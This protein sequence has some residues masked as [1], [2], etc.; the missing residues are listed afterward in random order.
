MWDYLYSDDAAMAFLL[1][2][3]HG[4]NGAVYPLGSGECRPLCEYVKDIRDLIN[5]SLEIGFGNK[6]YPVKQ[7]MYLES[8]N[9]QLSNDV[10]FSCHFLFKSGIRRILEDD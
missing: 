1:A 4:K 8:D 6:E 9:S 3:M 10:G 5:P 2:L 7:V